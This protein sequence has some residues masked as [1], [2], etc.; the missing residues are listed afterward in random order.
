MRW[1]SSQLHD[2]DALIRMMDP[3]VDGQFHVKSL[4]RFAD[5]ISRCIQVKI[6]VCIHVEVGIHILGSY[7][8]IIPIS[9]HVLLDV[10]VFSYIREKK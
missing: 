5:I 2:I 7:H 10:D 1:A 8:Y 3:C 9:Q 4:S 6:Y